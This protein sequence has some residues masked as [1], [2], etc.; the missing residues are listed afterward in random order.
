MAQLEE[1]GD[2]KNFMDNESLI[3]RGLVKG[4]EFDEAVFSECK[5]WSGGKSFS[6][7]KKS[8][9][10]IPPIIKSIAVGLGWDT[11]CDID[12]SILLFD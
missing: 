8:P 5:N 6:L 9:L 4:L 3:K 7:D 12:A 10:L 1:V 11:Y 2:G